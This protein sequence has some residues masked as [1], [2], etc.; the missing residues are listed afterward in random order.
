M[1]VTGFPSVNLVSFAALVQ[2]FTFWLKEVPGSLVMVAESDTYKPFC[3][4]FPN[5][6]CF[7]GY[8]SPQPLGKASIPEPEWLFS[9][10]FYF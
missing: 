5:N 8:F 1:M 7:A 3:P 9:C 4:A 2:T 10:G 6:C